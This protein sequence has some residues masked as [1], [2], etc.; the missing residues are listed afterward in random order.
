MHIMNSPENKNFLELVNRNSLHIDVSWAVRDRKSLSLQILD[1]FK[2]KLDDDSSSMLSPLIK[3]ES[4]IFSMSSEDKNISI[5]PKFV[6]LNAKEEYI[7]F[8]AE[9]QLNAISPDEHKVDNFFIK[10]LQYYYSNWH[11]K[12][13]DIK[14]QIFNRYKSL[15]DE[16]VDFLIKLKVYPDHY[17]SSKSN[18]FITNIFSWW[19]RNWLLVEK[20]KLDKIMFD[21]WKTP[22]YY[23]SLL[24]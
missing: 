2:W 4:D 10:T 22:E 11:I 20:A 17:F 24:N 15:F 7:E 5:F 23:I 8:Y 19:L 14:K 3:D 21:H 1:A 13:E 6:L 16:L 18:D 9:S 12:K